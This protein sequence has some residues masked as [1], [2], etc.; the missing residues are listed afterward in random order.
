MDVQS[1]TAAESDGGIRLDAFVAACLPALSRSRAGR[2]VRSGH[3]TVNGLR[4]KPGYLMKAG[5]RVC[6]QLPPVESPTCEPEPIP[7]SI[8]HED[9]D[10]I[11]INKPPGLVVHPGAGHKSGT[12]VNALLFHRPDLEGVGDA[13]RPGIVHRLDNDTSGIM[14]VAKHDAAYKSLGHQFK[15]RQIQKTYLGLVYG[16]MARSAGVIDLPIGRHPTDRKK[17]STRSRRGRSTETRWRI[18]ETFPGLTLLEIDLKTGRTHQ[19]RV[20]CAAM[21]HPIVGDTRYGRKRR[22]KGRLPEATEKAVRLV[23]RQMLHAWRLTLSHPE[24]G[25]MMSFSSPPAQDMA[26]LMAALRASQGK[27]PVA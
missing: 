4:K 26:S 2:L 19:A 11:V 15:S 8:L 27:S 10:L 18:R 23:R 14:V 22:W 25:D 21:G 9:R 6:A 3:I 7:L 17:M 1:L 12:L 5:D 16:E 24:T 13:L 20:H